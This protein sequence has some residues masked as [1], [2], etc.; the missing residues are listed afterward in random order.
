MSKTAVIIQ[1]RT[2]STRLPNKM[3]LPFDGERP[4]LAVL[5]GR[6]SSALV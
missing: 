5:L 6:I 1:A 4:V 2:G 3:A